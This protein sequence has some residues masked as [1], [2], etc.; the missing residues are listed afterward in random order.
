MRKKAPAKKPAKSP[1]LIPPYMGIQVASLTFLAAGGGEYI[2][3]AIT[4]E[5]RVFQ[6]RCN[7]RPDL[8]VL[9]MQTDWLPFE[10]K[11]KINA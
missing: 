5:G 11:E 2:V 3:F 9:N 4:N 8:N 7:T 10:V 6:V 1:P